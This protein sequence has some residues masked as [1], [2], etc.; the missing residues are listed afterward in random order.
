MSIFGFYFLQVASLEKQLQSLSVKNEDVRQ[1]KTSLVRQD[2]KKRCC[3]EGDGVLRRFLFPK[4]GGISSAPRKQQAGTHS[5]D[6]AA[7]GQ[8]KSR[9]AVLVCAVF[10]LRFSFGF[11]A[12]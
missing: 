9:S 8:I 10:K 11:D 4:G 7:T 5:N 2:I 1:K 3:F 12:I 6:A